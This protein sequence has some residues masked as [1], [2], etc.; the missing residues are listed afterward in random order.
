MRPQSQ[1]NMMSD[2]DHRLKQASEAWNQVFK[3]TKTQASK[4]VNVTHDEAPHRLNTIKLNMENL[5][6]NQPWGDI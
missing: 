4:K 2:I 6:S 5:V 3:N 1:S